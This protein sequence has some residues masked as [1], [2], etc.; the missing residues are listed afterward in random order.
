MSI[1][2]K[3]LAKAF[4]EETDES[5]RASPYQTLGKIIDISIGEIKPNPV[6]PRRY[7]SPA[8]LTSLAKSI[9]QDGIIQPLTVRRVEGTFEL[10]SGERRL[11]AAKLAGLRSV[12]CILINATEERSQVIALIENI[13]RCDL[14]FF[15]EA[16]AISQLITKYGMT[17]ESAAI[18]LGLAQSTV[19]NKL[20]ILKLNAEECKIILDNNMSERHARALLKITDNDRR[21]AVLNKATESGW[22]VDTLEKY[23]AKLLKDDEKRA[24]YHKRAAMLKDVRLFFNSVNKAI[25]VMRMAGVNADAKRIDHEDYIEYIIGKAGRIKCSTW[26]KKNR[27]GSKVCPNFFIYRCKKAVPNRCIPRCLTLWLLPTPCNAHQG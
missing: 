9:S 18:R 7:F 17:Q 6:Q 25:D 1:F 15:E 12:P 4:S 13:Q 11:R 3:T 2:P 22:T 19:A 21:L 23:I 5:Q 8:E 14:N 20:R 26:N 24:S 27:T 10:V 16:E